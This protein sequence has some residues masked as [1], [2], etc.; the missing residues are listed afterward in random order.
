MTSQYNERYR[1]V[2]NRIEKGIL[3][4][5]IACSILLVAGELLLQYEPV[6][7]LLIEIEQLEGVSR[8]P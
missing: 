6:R 4:G 7:M 1:R 5:I 3:A 2:S 8:T